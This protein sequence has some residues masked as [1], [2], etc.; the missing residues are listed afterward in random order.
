M[1]CYSRIWCMNNNIPCG[2]FA[3]HIFPKVLICVIIILISQ[4]CQFIKA[5]HPCNIQSEWIDNKLER[6]IFSP[7]TLWQESWTKIQQNDDKYVQSFTNIGE[8]YI[9][10]WEE[11]ETVIV[12]NLTQCLGRFFDIICQ[13]ASVS[14]SNQLHVVIFQGGVFV[15]PGFIP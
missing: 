12:Y 14:K 5:M 2:T 7:Q 1:R 4:N 13:N 9:L 10:S 11:S 15:D 3:I 6:G 8:V